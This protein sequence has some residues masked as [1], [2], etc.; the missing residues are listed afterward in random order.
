MNVNEVLENIHELSIQSVEVIQPPVMLSQ[1]S[2]NYI[3]ANIQFNY[4]LIIFTMG[5][6]TSLLFCHKKPISRTKFI[7]LPSYEP[8]K[9]IESDPI[10]AKV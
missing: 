4:L 2:F 10:L 8:P 1:E 3:L 7:V 5:C 6:F 9:S